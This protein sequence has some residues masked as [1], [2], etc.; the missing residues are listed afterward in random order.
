[1]EELA[2]T[3][4]EAARRAE[5]LEAGEEGGGRESADSELLREAL[6]PVR[7]KE[8]PRLRPA[9]ERKEPGAAEDSA[10]MEASRG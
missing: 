2:A 3:G 10:R 7:R 9:V 1:V 8:E 4:G 6:A 5:Q